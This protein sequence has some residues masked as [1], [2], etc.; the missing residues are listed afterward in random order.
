VCS[1]WTRASL[2]EPC[3]GRFLCTST[4]RCSGCAVSLPSGAARC[5]ACL[6]QAPPWRSCRTAV[7]YAFP[8][9]QLISAFKFRQQPD[10]ARLL[11]E[12]MQLAWGH[13]R[14]EAVDLVT[15]VPLSASRWHARGYN[16]AWLLARAAA[17]AYQL[18]ADPDLILRWRETPEQSGATDRAARQ[19]QVKGAFMP[20]PAAQARLRGRRIALVDDVMTTGAT[21]SAATQALLEGGAASVDLWVLARTPAPGA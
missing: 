4:A 13:H 17:K 11:A 19:Q 6:R 14:P 7:D 16:Q 5:G 15:A 10:T 20:S 18:P 1:S 12:V 21:A 8:W 2:C 9:V 3:K